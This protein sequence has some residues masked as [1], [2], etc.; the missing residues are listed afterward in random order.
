MERERRSSKSSMTFL[1]RADARTALERRAGPCDDFTPAAERDGGPLR[2]HR[3]DQKM[4]LTT[5]WPDSAFRKHTHASPGH[6]RPSIELQ[7]AQP[8]V[9][10]LA[11]LEDV[12]HAAP[13]S[14]VP[15]PQPAVLVLERCDLVVE[16]G[17][18]RGELRER[19]LVRLEGGRDGLRGGKRSRR[20]DRR[21]RGREERDECL[22]Q[23]L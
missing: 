4:T 15:P 16:Q 18:L 7:P 2:A 10:I 19:R 21:G 14:T 9:L 1:I 8:A 20:R 3:R 13:T 23:L 11:E 6:A 22:M 17:K 12:P 5:S